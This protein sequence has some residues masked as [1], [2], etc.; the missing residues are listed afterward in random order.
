MFYQDEKGGIE[1]GLIEAW[2]ISDDGRTY[3]FT[4]RQGVKWHNGRLL[5]AE[6]IAFNFRYWI[7]SP[8]S[9]H[10]T[11]AI[12][13]KNVISCDATGP[14]QVTVKLKHPQPLLLDWL[15]DSASSIVVPKEYGMMDADKVRQQPFGT[16]SW[17]FD[18]R[19]LGEDIR[20]TAFTEHWRKVP[21]FKDL[22]LKLI[23]E[24]STRLAMMQRG[25]ADIIDV[26]LSFRKE[27]AGVPV[28][29]IR[30]ADAF[31]SYLFFAGMYK[32]KEAP[33]YDPKL[34]WRDKRVRQALNLAIDRE[35]IA[36]HVFQ[37]E[38]RPAAVIEPLPAQ[39]GFKASWKP[40]PFRPDEA[41]ALLAEA[42]YPNGF[43]INLESYPRPGVPDIPLMVEAVADYWNRIGVKAKLVTTEW[44]VIRPLVARQ[45]AKDFAAPITQGMGVPDV[46]TVILGSQLHFFN[47]SPVVDAAI[48]QVETAA[49]VEQTATALGNLGDAM[50]A[51]YALV[52][53][54][55]LNQIY[56]VD[57]KTIVSWPV[58]PHQGGLNRLAYAT[59]V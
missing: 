13:I 32:D 15:S 28:K 17:K 31:S 41:K 24:P 10:N 26:P 35:A 14:H 56:G 23:P 36:D 38:A 43:E 54:D 50:I 47:S 34:P 59:K 49:T 46:L 2:H 18:S 45:Q 25:E 12:L 29:V 30:A 39:L 42:G 16:G 37:G 7:L 53:I 11:S 21:Q 55:L 19:S 48:A 22:V 8:L 27:V 52:P 51:E 57:P 3:T 33:G 1:P 40:Y 5:D 20:Y 9:K 4:V 6:D 58:R 44:A